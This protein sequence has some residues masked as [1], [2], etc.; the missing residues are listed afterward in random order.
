MR[1]PLVSVAICAFLSVL[2]CNTGFGQTHEGSLVEPGPWHSGAVR[3][4]SAANSPNSGIYGSIRGGGGAAPGASFKPVG[5]CVSVL[6]SAGSLIA[7]ATCN[8]NGEFRIALP[9]GSYRVAAAGQTLQ[10]LVTNASWSP[11]F[12]RINLR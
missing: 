5:P 8:K 10:V 11:A 12:F 2:A 3:T 4:A 7:T 6:D 9:A 1:L